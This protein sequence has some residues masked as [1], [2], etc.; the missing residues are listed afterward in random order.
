MRLPHV[1]FEDAAVLLFDKPSGLLVAPDRWDK[2]RENLMGSVHAARGTEVNNVHRLDA[3][4]SGVLLCA[5]TPDALRLLTAQ[6]EAHTVVKRYIALVAGRPA[7]ERFSVDHPLGEDP[8]KLGRMRVD[9]NNGKPA[10]TDFVVLE[11]FRA[12]TLVE[13]Q[14]KT[15]RTHQLRVHLAAIG[16]PIVADPFY[17]GAPGILLSALKPGYRQKRNEPERPL[18]GRLALHAAGLTFDHPITGVRTTV[19]SPMPKEFSVAMKYL[20]EFAPG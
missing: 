10:V 1:L 11:R 4:T 2:T 18:L 5:K 3:D 16:C 8:R 9:T 6:F 12:H 14:P 19:E 15:G 20:R 7:A 13:C 17:G